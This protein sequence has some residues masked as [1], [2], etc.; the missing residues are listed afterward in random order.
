MP[1]PV[2]SDRLVLLTA[3]VT[4]VLCGGG[5]TVGAESR[6]GFQLQFARYVSILDRLGPISTWAVGSLS[7]CGVP[8]KAYTLEISGRE[9]RWVNGLGSTD[10][11]TIVYADGFSFHTYTTDSL[12]NRGAQGQAAGQ[13]WVYTQLPDGRI[14]VDP[15]GKRSFMLVRC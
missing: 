8:S 15:Y 12:R 1:M 14:R 10:Y 5:P 4:A 13:P 3:L 9:V 7:N 2:S 6:D 11:E